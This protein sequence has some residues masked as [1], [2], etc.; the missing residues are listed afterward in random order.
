MNFYVL[1]TGGDQEKPRALTRIPYPLILYH[2]IKEKTLT[3]DPNSEIYK[4]YFN[5]SQQ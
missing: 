4:L 2:K 3:A 5:E 1:R